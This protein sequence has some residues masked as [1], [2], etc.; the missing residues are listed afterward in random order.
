MSQPRNTSGRVGLA[1]TNA[2]KLGGL[3][4]VFYDALTDPP[5]MDPA[6]LGLAAFMMAGA[7]GFESFLRAFL[8]TGGKP[9]EDK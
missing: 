6:T 1:I 4:L 9:P 3:A 8:G 2:I 7:Q 5:G